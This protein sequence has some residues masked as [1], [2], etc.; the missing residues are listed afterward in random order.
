MALRSG[1]SRLKP[2]GM[3]N[4]H[5]SLVFK[6]YIF[7]FV[8]SLSEG[9]RSR[10]RFWCIDLIPRGKLDIDVSN[11]GDILK[12]I[13]F[14]Q[15]DHQL[16]LTNVSLLRRFLLSIKRYDLLQKLKQV[17][18]RI[19]VG[20]ILENY[21][22]VTSDV[23]DFVE[24][25]GFLVGT[26]ENNQRPISQVLE[27]FKQV[28]DDSEVLALLDNVFQDCQQSAWSTVSILLVIMGELHSS[29]SEKEVN[30]AVKI[31]NELFVE[32]ML[33]LGGLVSIRKF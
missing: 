12:L 31:C 33:K 14:L 17:K 7:L 1:T 11:D 32:W 28:E 6:E 30:L 27:Q 25:E 23:S 29:D 16:S 2:L 13:E 4:Y 5:H 8:N 3:Q 22:R 19:A 9:D 18:F 26:R 24:I 21:S 10:F 20:S 15:D